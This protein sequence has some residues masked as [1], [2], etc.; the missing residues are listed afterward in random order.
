MRLE[1]H[2]KFFSIAISGPKAPK[3]Y[4]KNMHAEQVKLCHKTW[5]SD[6]YH[7]QHCRAFLATSV[8]EPPAY[9]CSLE[10]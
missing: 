9:L 1:Y 10:A 4:T 8:A 3:S 6:T 5:T 2:H 7:L